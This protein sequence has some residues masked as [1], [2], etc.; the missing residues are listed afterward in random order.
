[1]KQPSVLPSYDNLET[2]TSCF[3]NYFISKIDLIREKL[4]GNDDLRDN[5]SQVQP[6][7]GVPL[8]KF[9]PATNKEVKEIITSL[10]NSSCESDPIPTSL[11]KQCVEPLVNF[12]TPIVNMSL[13]SGEFPSCLKHTLV[14]KAIVEKVGS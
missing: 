5:T 7:T 8:T 14:I 2:L 6:Y 11:L 1:M 13:E 10:K 9:E 3:S 12:L 4:S